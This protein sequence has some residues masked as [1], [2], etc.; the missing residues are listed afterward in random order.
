MDFLEKFNRR[1]SNYM[2]WRN[3]SLV[4]LESRNE[5]LE[6]FNE[7]M[8]WDAD[9]RLWSMQSRLWSSDM[10]G[11]GEFFCLSDGCYEYYQ[12]WVHHCIKCGSTNIVAIGI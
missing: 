3:S 12:S 9:E 7:E 6:D 10:V 1:F 8:E 5:P 11:C 2:F 4:R